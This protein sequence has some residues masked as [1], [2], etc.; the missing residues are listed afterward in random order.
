[1]LLNLENVVRKE[2]RGRAS[3]TVFQPV[4]DVDSGANCAGKRVNSR[5]I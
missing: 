3:E 2:R 1:V 5:V 4:E